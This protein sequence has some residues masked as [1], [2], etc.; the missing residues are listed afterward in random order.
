LQNY[1]AQAVAATLPDFRIAPTAGFPQVLAEWRAAGSDPKTKPH[2]PVPFVAAAQQLVLANVDALIKTPLELRQQYARHDRVVAWSNGSVLV[3]P[4]G[5]ADAVGTSADLAAAP[6][7]IAWLDN[8]KS[9]LVW[10]DNEL[11]LLNGDDAKLKWKKIELKGLPKIDVV[12]SGGSDQTITGGGNNAENENAQV[13]QHLQLRGGRRIINGRVIGQ[14]AAVA[15]NQP[16]QVAAAAATP[17]V[18][19][20]A[21]VRPVD[22]KVIVATTAGQLFAIRTD[23]GALVWHTRLAAAAPISR[24]AATDDFVVAKVDDNAGTQLVVLDTLTGQLARPRL[25]FPSEQGNA[26]VNFALAPDGTLVWIQPDRLC[27]KDLFEPRKDLNYEVMAGQGDNVRNPNNV[28]V[29]FNRQ[30]MEATSIYGGAVNPDQLLIS[31]GRILVVAQNGRYVC[32]HSLETGK[33]LD[34]A[35]G[36]GKRAEARLATAQGD[37]SKSVADWGVALHLVGSRLYVCSRQNGPVCYNLDKPGAL[38]SGSVETNTVPIIEFREPFIGQDFFVILD[39][40]A[41]RVGANPNPNTARL[42]CFSRARVDPKGDRESGR[43]DQ[44]PTITDPA[45]ISEFQGVDGGFYYLTGDHKLHFLK[46]ARP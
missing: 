28:N 35:Q 46:G 8:N 40:P 29:N 20:I 34:F 43:L 4:V 41:A 7:N 9:L 32:I 18:E 26:P 2:L 11:A 13:Q 3:Y 25:N 17:G 31:E 12:A 30:Q 37:A 44:V 22:D 19:A 16:P 33:L 27:G 21:S 1:K 14:V 24:L 6:K 10:N 36:D 15:V 38:W 45:G 42:H 23:T 39:H 5:K